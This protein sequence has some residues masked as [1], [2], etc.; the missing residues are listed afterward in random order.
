M[1][2]RMLVPCLA[3]LALASI[4]LAQAQQTNAYRVGVILQGGNFSVV[5][6]GLKDGLKELGFDAG[7]QYA[8]EIRDLK[9]DLNAAEDTARSLERE[10]VDLTTR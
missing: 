8:L 6:E 9:G 1:C 2:K 5:V 3:A 4:H 10:K 7:K